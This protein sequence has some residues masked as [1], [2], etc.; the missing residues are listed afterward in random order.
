MFHEYS[1]AG[2]RA[3]VVHHAEVDQRID[4]AGAEHVARL[5]AAQIDLM[6]LD[7]LRAARHRPAIEADD[8]ASRARDGAGARR[9]D[10]AGP[11][12]R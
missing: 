1:S 3:R 11:R 12:C 2:A 7:V 10:R 5:L 6:M 4:V 8:L 9:S